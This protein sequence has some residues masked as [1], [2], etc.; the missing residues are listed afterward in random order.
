MFPLR[1]LE[2]TERRERDPLPSIPVKQMD[3][4]RNGDKR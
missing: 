3:E 2:V 1:G 4:Q